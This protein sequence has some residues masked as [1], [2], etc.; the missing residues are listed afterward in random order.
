[1]LR[2]M[3]WLFPSHHRSKV[4]QGWAEPGRL[5]VEGRTLT[6]LESSCSFLMAGEHEIQQVTWPRLTDRMWDLER[7]LEVTK[8]NLLIFWVMQSRFGEAGLSLRHADWGWEASILPS[9]SPFSL[10]LPFPLPPPPLFFSPLFPSPLPLR[11]P[12]HQWLQCSS[13]NSLPSALLDSSPVRTHLCVI[14]CA[15]QTVAWS[16]PS[17]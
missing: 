12:P 5:G 6:T 15:G 1:M 17:L 2:E 9:L 13:S 8:L 14:N 3:K 4:A 16:F 11:L 10:S 7:V